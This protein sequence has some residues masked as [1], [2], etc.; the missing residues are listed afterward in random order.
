MAKKCTKKCAA[1]TNLF[2]LL[3]RSID[4]VAVLIAVAVS[5]TQFYFF[6]Y[7]YVVNESLVF[8]PH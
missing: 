3:I 4:F 6:V 5:L 1:R 8:S 7:K 2:V